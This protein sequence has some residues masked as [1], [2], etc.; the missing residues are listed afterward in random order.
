MTAWKRGS[1]EKDR[2][3]SFLGL[4]I[5]AGK[6]DTGELAVEKSISSGKAVLV[7]ISEDASAN[8][9]KQFKDKCRFYNVPVVEFGEKEK[10]GHATGKSERTSLAVTDYGLAQALMKKLLSG[11]QDGGDMNG[12]N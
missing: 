5:R 11:E 7:I 12:E 8:T 1:M 4:C 2:I 3:Y 10:L 9:K 6:L